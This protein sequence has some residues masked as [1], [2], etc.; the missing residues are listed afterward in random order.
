MGGD[1]G[2]GVCLERTGPFVGRTTNWLYDH[3][4]FLPDR[5]LLILCDRLV[6]REEFPELTA[7]CVRREGLLAAVFRRLGGCELDWRD[8]VQLSRLSPQ[9][10]HSHFGSVGLRDARLRRVLNLP[11]VVSFYGADAY[12]GGERKL[13]D[14]YGTVFAEA[15][16]IL[17]LG[18]AMR[19]RLIDLGCSASKVVIHPLGVDGESLPFRPRRIHSSEP[20]RIVFAGTLREK[21]GVQ[22]LV[23]A[24]GILRRAGVKF[25]LR[26]VGDAA[27]K[28]GDRESKEAVFRR[29]T[30]LDLEGV[31]QHTGFV[32]FQQLLAWA[33]ESHVFVAP[34]VVASSGDREGTPFVL[35]QMMATAMP[36]IATWHSDVPYVFGDYAPRMLVPERNA[37]AIA[38]RLQRY[39][40]QPEALTADGMALRRRILQ[41]F[42]VRNCAR[43]LGALYDEVSS[44]AVSQVDGFRD[45][46]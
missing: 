32:S 46:M 37:G 15:A 33:L 38:E 14:R 4:R 36:C 43:R 31:V 2:R 3:L 18:P 9:V 27:G 41:H 45:W 11:W 24:A 7:R 35:Q 6:N 8:L 26:L 39:Y 25:H 5:E 22:Y 29:I 34:S 1:Q 28:T 30:E 23:E 19:Q 20:L 16:R 42:D 12:E 17:A 40:E 21:K 10:L 44:G 13:R